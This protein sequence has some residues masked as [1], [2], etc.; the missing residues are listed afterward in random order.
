MKKAIYPGSFDPL[1]MGHVDIILR[2]ASLFDELIVCVMNNY[3][4]KYLFTDLERQELVS[5]TFE[6]YPNI[7]V[8]IYNGLVVDYA[9]QVG[10]IAIV[11]GLRNGEDFGFEQ[12]MDYHNNRLAPEIETTFLMARNENL[13]LS[14]SVVKEILTFNGDIHGLVPELVEE[15]LKTKWSELI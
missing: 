7:K 14:S 9:K 10:A 4:K 2:G 12:A 1:T 5:S 6:A 15:R 13:H 11:K 3:R 8:E